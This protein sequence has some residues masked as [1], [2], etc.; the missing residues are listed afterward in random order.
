MNHEISISYEWSP[1]LVRIGTRRY[2]A[3]HVGSRLVAFAAALVVAAIALAAGS[4][5]GFW[6]VVIIVSALYLLIWAGHDL[7][8]VKMRDERP[9]PMVS[10][11]MEPECITFQSSEQTTTM[12]WSGFKK[13][14]RFKEVL[15]VFLHGQRAYLILPAGPL[16]EEGRRFLE[17]KVREHGG[18]VA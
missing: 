1:E 14:W 15:L 17:D 5:G 2:I 16:G 10:I 18:Q 7:R 11:R 13:L 3:R 9:D 12:K 6:W 4:A 8:M